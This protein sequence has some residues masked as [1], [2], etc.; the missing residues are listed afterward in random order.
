MYMVSYLPGISMFFKLQLQRRVD[1]YMEL[2]INTAI[3]AD[4]Y[5]KERDRFKSRLPK[6]HTKVYVLHNARPHT[7]KVTS[8]K[9][10]LLG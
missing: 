6:N 8:E 7:A 9:I 1:A 3:T 4:I 10:M 2:P 5:C